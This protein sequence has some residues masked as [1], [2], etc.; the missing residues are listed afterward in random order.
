[1]YADLK[2]GHVL[3]HVQVRVRWKTDVNFFKH[4]T[5]STC[6]KHLFTCFLAILNM[7]EY[8]VRCCNMLQHVACFSLRLTQPYLQGVLAI[9]K[10]QEEQLVMANP[11]DIFMATTAD[12]ANMSV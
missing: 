7:Y 6:L 9:I 5:T 8:A 12:A 11:S 10:L 4:A 1:M 2:G 3:Q